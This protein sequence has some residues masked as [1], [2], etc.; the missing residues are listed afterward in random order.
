M[1]EIYRRG[2]WV[3]RGSLCEIPF[4]PWVSTATDYYH[5][6]ISGR[7]YVVQANGVGASAFDWDA[8][9]D[10][11]IPPAIGR[12]SSAREAVA[13]CEGHASALIGAVEYGDASM[14]RSRI[15]EATGN[16]G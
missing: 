12:F 8:E 14:F 6:I 11:S 3:E 16:V 7:H 13:A 5:A 2:T 15:G 1:D 4:G 10:F 9:G